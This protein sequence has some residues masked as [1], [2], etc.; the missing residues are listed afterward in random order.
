MGF[1]S[2]YA[3]GMG[4]PTVENCGFCCVP[5]R[6]DQSKL[7]L[8]PVTYVGRNMLFRQSLAL[9]KLHD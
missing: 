8:A 1:N 4:M 5:A 9:S 3:Q 6:Q 7:T 2:L